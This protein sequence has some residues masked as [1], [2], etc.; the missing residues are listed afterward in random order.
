MAKKVKKY[1]LKTNKGAAKRFKATA[2]GKYRFRHAER[3]HGNTKK[4]TKIM[5]HRRSNGV[6][7]AA[8]TKIVD[9]LLA[10]R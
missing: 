8:D 4:T 3:A 7:S 2:S 1:K 10:V 9:A 6:L 5:R